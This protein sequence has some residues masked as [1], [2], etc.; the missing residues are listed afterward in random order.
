[1][2]GPASHFLFG[3][4]C[5]A[6]IGAIAIVSTPLR[7]RGRTRENRQSEIGNRKW[8]LVLYLPPFV[9]G[10]GFWGEL[11][12]LMGASETTH[13][14][15][16]VFFGYAW[17]HPWLEGQESVAFFAV[18]LVANLFLLGY[19]LFV[20]SCFSTAALVRWE[21][22]GPE[23]AAGRGSAPERRHGGGRRP[24][25]G[26]PRATRGHSGRRRSEGQ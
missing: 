22:E 26:A 18:L 16:N 15:A 6:A 9:L 13:P 14:L 11:P 2:M 1:M 8:A 21:R 4:L 25:S 10:C 24:A 5:G 3:A 17:L 7:G 19:V 20:S 23:G 12:Y